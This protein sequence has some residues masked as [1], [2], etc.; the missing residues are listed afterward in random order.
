M[1]RTV[2]IMFKHVAGEDGDF[3]K[4]LDG[5]EHRDLGGEAAT[6]GV[7]GSWEVRSAEDGCVGWHALEVD[8]QALF[9]VAGS[10]RIDTH[11]GHGHSLGVGDIVTLPGRFPYR[12]QLSP[13][14]RL[15]EL[16]SPADGAVIAAPSAELLEP[17]SGAILNYEVPEAYRLG[18]SPT[19][20]RGFLR[21]RDVG[22]PAAVAELVRLE[23]IRAESGGHSSGWHHH[24]MAQ[25]V[26]GIQGS[27]VV[28]VEGEP[29]PKTITAGSAVYLP[30]GTAHNLR[31]IS[32]DYGLLEAFI[33]AIGGTVQ[34]DPPPGHV[35]GGSAA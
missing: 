29:T 20:S 15:I 35:V 34:C 16:R 11:V 24:P 31:D 3:V 30:P 13:D 9:V 4:R 18:V 8:L 5:A 1:T 33:P 12:M 7:L 32:D 28:D 6:G 21:Y 19:A 2:D 23:I 14:A 22:V 10:V 17:G 25:I 26:F 27:A